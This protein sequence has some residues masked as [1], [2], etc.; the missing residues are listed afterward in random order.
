MRCIALIRGINV[1]KAKRI[2]MSDLRA[3]VEGLGHGDV[4]T[5]LNS[6]NVVF[7]AASADTGKL[8]RGIEAAIEKNAGFSARVVVVTAPELAAV[9]MANPFPEATEKPS[10]FLLAFTE[11]ASAKSPLAPLIDQPWKP[12]RFALGSRAAYVWCANGI[13][14]SKLAVTVL[15]MGGEAVTTRNWATVLKLADLSK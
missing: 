12:D 13:L 9:I 7:R 5:L 11:G 8:A 2:S 15:K 1:G 6:G 10:Q 3:L 4:K 14:T